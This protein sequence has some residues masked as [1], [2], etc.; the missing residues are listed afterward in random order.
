AVPGGA[1]ARLDLP[2][3]DEIAEAVHLRHESREDHGRRAELLDDP[4]PRP[5]IAR[6]QPRAAGDR[7]LP[8]AAIEDDGA[9]AAARAVDLAV[10]WRELGELRP[11]D[12]AD[13]GGTHVHPFDDLSPAGARSWRLA[14][15]VTEA[16]LVSRV[17]PLDC[18]GSGGLV[19]GTGW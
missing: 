17:E 2:S 19:H 18:L 15:G 16:L 3:Q 1:V 13:A 11:L 7:T 4:G 9:R 12:R 14:I 8:Q 5:H 6:R 10:T